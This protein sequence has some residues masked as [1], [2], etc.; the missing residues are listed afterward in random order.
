MI[1]TAQLAATPLCACMYCVGEAS[2]YVC[3]CTSDEEK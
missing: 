1:N 3:M 2:C